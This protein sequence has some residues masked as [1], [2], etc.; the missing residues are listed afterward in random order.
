M[1]KWMA[2]AWPTC[3]SLRFDMQGWLDQYQEESLMPHIYSNLQGYLGRWVHLL[4][5]GSHLTM[6]ELLEW[7]DCAFSYV[8]EYNTMIQSLYEIRLKEGESVE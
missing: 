8:C 6:T 3:S 2:L 7:M 4:E 5:D 1:Y